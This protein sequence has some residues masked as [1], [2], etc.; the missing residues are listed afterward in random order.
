MAGVR[1]AEEQTRG[2]RVHAGLRLSAGDSWE[3]SSGTA[4]IPNRTGEIP[5][6]GMKRGD[7]GNV[8]IIRSPVRAIVL[9]NRLS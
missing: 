5:P 8:G 1:R 9:P 6:S 7:D 2:A 3:D 4:T